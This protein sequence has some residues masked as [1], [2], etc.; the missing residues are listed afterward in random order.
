MIDQPV[1]LDQNPPVETAAADPFPTLGRVLSRRVQD[2]RAMALQERRLADNEHIA[3]RNF[4]VQAQKLELEKIRH[5]TE[6]QKE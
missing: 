3:Q 4:A 6:L 2:P 5:L 1:D